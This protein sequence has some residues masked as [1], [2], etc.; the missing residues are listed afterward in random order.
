MEVN[1]LS[2]SD[3]APE[4]IPVEA[5]LQKTP[6]HPIMTGHNSTPCSINLVSVASLVFLSSS[7]QSALCMWLLSAKREV[8]SASLYNSECDGQRSSC[9]WYEK[10]LI[11]T[12]SSVWLDSWM[13]RFVFFMF[14][15]TCLMSVVVSTTCEAFFVFL[16]IPSPLNPK[17]R[18]KKKPHKTCWQS[19]PR[20]L[21]FWS[22][23]LRPDG[24]LQHT[25][26]HSVLAREGP[27]C[28]PSGQ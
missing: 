9:L 16:S 12:E 28:S 27:A 21:V 26:S 22:L 4:P 23:C 15:L 1:L 6:N 10:R 7:Q 14:T 17:K 5:V 2:I 19:E 18:R 13:L 11:I 24:G 3:G 25:Q 8:Q 20:C